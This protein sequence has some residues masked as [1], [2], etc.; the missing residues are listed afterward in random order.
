MK[1]VVISDVH[2]RD[3]WKEIVEETADMYIFLGDYFDSFYID[4]KKQIENFLEIR[5]FYRHNRDK[6]ILLSG[7]H[8]SPNYDAPDYAG[9]CSGFQNGRAF[10]IKN[11]IHEMREDGELL[12][13]KTI[14]NYLF[15]HA[16]ISKTWC[17][18]YNID[19]DQD[20]ENQVNELFKKDMFAFTFQRSGDRLVRENGYGD[21]IYQSPMW[22]RIKSLKLDKIPKYIQVIGHTPIQGILNENDIW[23]TDCQENS[24]EFLIL[25]I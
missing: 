15:V 2:G 14:K 25:D 22:I 9:A 1:V 16:G 7:N 11:L 23:M 3:N 18:N 8:D 20:L 17:D 4:G 13:C 10:Q 21:N 12:A 24:D 5:N 19:L 6:V